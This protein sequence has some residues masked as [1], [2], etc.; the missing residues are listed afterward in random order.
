MASDS[1]YINRRNFLKSST[2]VLALSSFGAY[3][4]DLVYSQKRYRVGLIGCGWYGTSD[5]LKLIQVTNVEVV[6]LCDVDRRHLEEAANLV[7]QRQ[8]SGKKPRLYREYRK[9]L[10]EKDLD[11]VLIGSPD[12][13]HALQA[14]EAMESG[15]HLYLQ[16]PISLDVLEGESILA[17]AR[18]LGKKVQIG[19][20]RRS[21]PHL[22]DG[23]KNVIDAGLLGKISHVEM[24]C[25]YHMRWNANPPVQEI[26]EYLDYD[27]WSGPAP[28]RPYVGSPHR[29]WRA[30]MEYGNGIVGDMCVHMLDTVRWMLD[31]GWPKKISSTGGI[32]VQK[33]AIANIS[34]TQNAVFEFDELN[35]I[36]Q[37]RSWGTPPDPEYPWAFFIYGEK[38][39]FKGSVHQYEFIPAGEGETLKKQVV[40]EREKYPEDLKEKDIELHT[41]PATRRHML[42]LLA[43]IEQD[44]LPVADVEEGHIST[45]SCIMANLAMELERPLVYHPQQRIIVDDTEATALLKRNYRG[46]WKHPSENYL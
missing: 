4:L 35:C 43:S 29:R 27:L 26:P 39:T 46:P 6:S 41:A 2:A 33:D 37:H 8:S 1:F 9:M 44:T 42:D 11:I 23:K 13:W 10:A 28:L 5:L 14:I 36:W 40:Y 20:Q 34:D 15:A 25:Y 38:G 45:A 3:G 24:C 17:T 22:I 16:K 32:Y 12:H 7:A 31:L 18:K 30:F 19:T 21:T